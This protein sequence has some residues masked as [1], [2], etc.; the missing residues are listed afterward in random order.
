[1]VKDDLSLARGAV[2]SLLSRHGE[3]DARIDRVCRSGGGLSRT[4]VLVS[5]LGAQSIPEHVVALVPRALREANAHKVWEREASVLGAL[6]RCCRGI[7]V[8]SFVGIEWCDGVPIL[9]VS[10]VTGLTLGPRGIIRDP[11]RYLT[12]VARV[13][14]VVHSLPYV[15][16]Q[17]ALGPPSTCRAFALSRLS[18]F[19]AHPDPDIQRAYRWCRERL[20]D[21]TP[22][23]VLH[24]DLLGQNLLLNQNDEAILGVLNWGEC[25]SGDPAYELA[26]VTRG[27]RNPW[28]VIDGRKRLLD[29]YEESGGRSISVERVLFYEALLVM[30]WLA[31]YLECDP[32]SGDI[33]EERR[34]LATVLKGF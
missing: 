16:F 22:T 32:S 21:D 6:A 34:R 15:D 2:R 26:V 25:C 3:N 23:V 4:G 9:L 11:I 24:G 17:E 8:P 7:D 30:G 12:S 5:I 19:S 31:H 18:V 14:S 20:P 28:K 29:W 13:A 10:V 27:V 1:M 33:G